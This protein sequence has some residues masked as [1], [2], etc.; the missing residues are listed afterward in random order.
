MVCLSLIAVGP[1]KSYALEDIY[2]RPDGSIEPASAPIV[3]VGD[4]YTFTADLNHALRVERDNIVINAAGYASG[5]NTTLKSSGTSYILYGI[6]LVGRNNVTLNEIK[7]R[8]WLG[9][10][11][12]CIVYGCTGSI[13][14]DD[15]Y[16][17]SIVANNITGSLGLRLV[18]SHNNNIYGNHIRLVSNETSHIMIAVLLSGSN[19]N[20][21]FE[22]SIEGSGTAGLHLSGASNNTILRNNF[23]SNNE[24]AGGWDS[25]GNV[26]DNGTVGNYWNDFPYGGAYP[27]QI[28]YMKD[29]S[30]KTDYDNQ[31]Q[32]QPFIILTYP[33]PK[34]FYPEASPIL[35]PTPSP[36]IP[37]F[38][39]WTILAIAT[40]TLLIAIASK[41]NK[42]KPQK[43][44][45]DQFSG[46]LSFFLLLLDY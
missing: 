8:I 46:K 25:Y 30:I 45:K 44:K 38:S 6:E 4:V 19:N 43:K 23:I 24:Q 14:L 42:E 27:I 5:G 34:P 20:I 10:V 29:N 26:W 22:N 39:Q 18:N 32:T 36:S 2:I 33:M 3:R 35:T 17:N 13:N 1:V 11:S 9:N 37:E 7:G 40:A 28:H 21:I 12:N 16:N 31:A 15:A 41:R